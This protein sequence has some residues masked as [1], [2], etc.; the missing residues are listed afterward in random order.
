MVAANPRA[1]RLPESG[2]VLNGSST[3]KRYVG[4]WVQVPSNGLGFGFCRESRSDGALVVYTD[5]PR[6]A[7]S[8]FV[9]PVASLVAR[10]IS[11]GTRVWLKG[12]PYGWHAAEVTSATGFDEYWVRVAGLFKDI[13]VHGA[14]LVIRWNQPLRDPVQALAHGFCDSPEYYSARR[15]FLDQLIQQRRTSRGF[16]AILS[17]PVDLYHHQLD[18][19]ARVL[20][21]PVL[22]Y[23]L[24]DEV[25]LGK[26]VEAGLILRQLLLDDPSATV[27][28]CVPSILVS[29]WRDELTERLLLDDA[30]RDGRLQVITH[31]DIARRPD[32]C[33]HALVVVDEAHRIVSQLESTRIRSDLQRSR[34]LLLLSAT[35]MRGNLRTFLGLLNLVDPIAFPTGDMAAFRT[36][37]AQRESSASSVQVLASRR[38]SLRQRRSALD[39]LATLHGADPT[40]AR[41]SARCHET[42]ETD[43]PV[44]AELAEYIRETYRISRRMIRHRRNAGI[45]HGYPVSGR[46]ATFVPL[47]DPARPVIDD[48]LD[49]Y[50][51]HLT[52]RPNRVGYARTVLAALSGPATLLRHLESALAVGRDSNDAVPI[53][54]RTLVETTVARL[55]LDGSEARLR[56]ALDIVADRM[57]L[58]RKVVVVSTFAQAAQ[59]FIQA[60]SQIWGDQVQGHLRHMT[61]IERDDG[62][63]AFLESVGGQV[64]VGDYTIE[65][66]RNLQDAN[67]LVNLD[68]PLDPNR[69]EQRIG[70]LDRFAKQGSPAEVVVLIEPD[71]EWQSAYVALLDQ[72]LGIFD[73]SVATVQRRLAEILDQLINSLVVLGSQAFILDLPVLR[74]SLL[75]EQ[76]DVD[77]LEELE[78]VT[79]AADFDDGSMADLRAADRDVTALRSAFER[80]TSMSGGIGLRP[81]DDE[82]HALVRFANDRDGRGRPRVRRISGLSED[83][84]REVAALLDQP[85]A[86]VRDV[87]ASRRGVPLLRLGDPLVDWIDRYLRDDER[88]R[89]R[90]IVRPTASVH[91]PE[92]WLTCD[93]LVEFDAVRLHAED[94]GVRRRL[95]RRGDAI[96]PPD[97]IRTWTDAHG[98]ASPDLLSTVLEAPFDERVDRVLR[99]PVWQDVRAELP[100]WSQLCRL[101][102]EAAQD[103][104]A[105]TPALTELPLA[106]AGRAKREVQYRTAVLRARSHHL[107]TEA[108]RTSA[109]QEMRRE[110]EL[111]RALIEGV[112]QPAVSVIACGGV[113]LWPT[114]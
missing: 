57:A 54:S 25:G 106:A 65:E 45:A 76:A 52:E 26:T 64:L 40:F 70:R 58:G 99:G 91:T 27:L 60:A 20:A 74:A 46:R 31:E 30:I 36:R 78:S 50:R 104:L 42:A 107:P 10:R 28:V 79:V 37:V 102:F 15:A 66:G 84:S 97:V 114:T 22:R 67:V 75:D 69:L 68:L 32:L 3:Q 88:G 92:L 39:R 81:V 11:P 44:W 109:A 56:L 19:V 62:I 13:R 73:S 34:G 61:Q 2:G 9:V 12:N 111:G 48:F 82:K 96:L 83:A 49:R 29:Q 5:I 51:E 103:H 35:P 110:E 101:S 112:A 4:H 8:E 113:V 1:T 23:L 105:T 6:V 55:R 38:A 33:E 89:T 17:A 43:S 90:A 94:E 16:T 21:D 98:L 53:N 14:K 47:S 7:E 24:A 86:Y 77:L 87:A 59:E 18:T 85:R 63:L 72:G 95:R 100:E 80:L 41:M 108:E 71:S 93:F